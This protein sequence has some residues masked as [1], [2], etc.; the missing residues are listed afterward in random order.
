LAHAEVTDTGNDS[1][2]DHE[3]QWESLS[4][5]EMRAF[6]LRNCWTYARTMPQ[7]PHEY[8]VLW[9]A[10]SENDFFRFAMT[11]RRQGY[12]EHFYRKKMRYLD[13]DRLRYWTMGDELTTTWVLNRALNKGPDVPHARN[14]AAFVTNP[15]N[16]QVP[17]RTRRPAGVMIHKEGQPL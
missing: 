12:D 3:Q 5:S 6:A 13:V 17:P 10:S 4:L 14:P 7:H 9:S 1:E 11:I 8:V 16:N 15:P 2:S